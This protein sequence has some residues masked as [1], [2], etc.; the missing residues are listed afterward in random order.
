M[1]KAFITHDFTKKTDSKKLDPG[2]P[3]I[4][5]QLALTLNQ[6]SQ[7][8]PTCFREGTVL[9]PTVRFSPRACGPKLERQSETGASS[10]KAALLPCFF[11][12]EGESFEVLTWWKASCW[13]FFSFFFFTQNLKMCIQCMLEHFGK[14]LQFSSALAWMW[15]L[16]SPCKEAEF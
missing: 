13:V 16:A 9:G 6:W 7:E 10:A 3:R 8:K 2:R 4:G 12:T 14:I 5:Q 15:T 1:L 11:T